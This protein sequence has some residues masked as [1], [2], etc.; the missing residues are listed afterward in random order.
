MPFLVEFL[1]KLDILHNAI[2]GMEGLFCKLLSWLLMCLKS[3]GGVWKHEEI[4]PSHLSCNM[5][6]TD[7]THLLRRVMAILTLVRLLTGELGISQRS[8]NSVISWA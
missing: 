1:R 7:M 5:L 3:F 2:I 4:D 6:L 8:L